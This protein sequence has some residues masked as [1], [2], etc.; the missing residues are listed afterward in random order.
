[1]LEPRPIQLDGAFTYQQAAISAVLRALAQSHGSDFAADF[2][3]DHRAAILTATRRHLCGRD[4]RA[5]A[6]EALR[7]GLTH[8]GT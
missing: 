4:V 7:L 8:K 5:V 2:V 1:V 3:R 6:S